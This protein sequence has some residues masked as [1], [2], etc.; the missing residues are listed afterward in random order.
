MTRTQAWR[1]FPG[2]ASLLLAGVLGA[3]AQT[4]NFLV[5]Q[6]DTDT[7][8][9]YGNLGW[10]TA[11][12]NITW[13]TAK[14]KTT[15]L[16]P[17]IAESGSVQW[18]IDWSANPP[19]DQ[20]MVNRR[21]PGDAVLDLVNYTNLSL[22]IWFDPSS[23]TDGAG[24]F[25]GIEVDWTPQ[26]EGWP[27]TQAGTALFYTTNSGWMH[28]EIPFD[29][30][31]DPK[32]KAVTH[33][34]FK[35][36]QSRTGAPLTGTSLFWIDNII[37][38]ARAATIPPPTLS[39]APVT[40]PPGLMV[41]SGGGGNGYR[42]GMI[43]TLDNAAGTPN[44]SWVGQGDV[45]VTYSLSI[46]N[47]LPGYQ[48]LQSHIFL[49]PN[50]ANDTSIDYNA[51]T[52]LALDVR[53]Q[54]DGTAAAVF[55]YKT[56]HAYANAADYRPATLICSNGVLGTWSMTFLHD[57]NVTVTAPDGSVTNFNIPQEVA[58]EFYNPVSAYF[59]TMQNGTW[60]AGAAATF[61]SVK[62]TGV[63][64]SPEIN[65]T[66]P[67]PDLNPDPENPRWRVVS[68]VPS[69]VFVVRPQHKY[70]ANWTLPDSGFS[71]QTSATMQGAWT[72]PGLTNVINTTMGNRLLIPQESLPPGNAGFF[73]LAKPIP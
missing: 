40:T 28:V 61:S 58:F 48:Y 47:Y 63:T 36:Q 6:F 64:Q 49:V 24:S 19:T 12:P 65:E 35:L 52:A 5:D 10:G 2:I 16:G 41:L 56:N 69:C 22:D 17:N 62:I 73:R 26:S 66:F 27:S 67:G 8:T 14:N 50:G 37:L 38:H 7:S 59:G 53:N 32:L 72:D 45:A 15:T 11:Y 23:A 57:T 71:L 68:D 31:A 20:V 42:R 4:T 34:G 21:F 30:S 1:F 55:R 43:R 3:H 29:A 33:V 9:Y 51:A 44:Y 18:S 54:A 25:G 39:L 60:N 46:T 13:D 70:W